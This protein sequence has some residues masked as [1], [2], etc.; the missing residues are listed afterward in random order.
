MSF[1]CDLIPGCQA[2]ENLSNA[3][4]WL[5][6]NW[7]IVLGIILLIILLIGVIII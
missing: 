6:N 7:V 1:L 4:D 5:E 3:L 2:A